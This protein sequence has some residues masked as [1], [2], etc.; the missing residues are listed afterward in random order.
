MKLSDGTVIA[1]RQVP[2]EELKN[3]LWFLGYIYKQ[4]A[5]I[6]VERYM[7]RLTSAIQPYTSTDNSNEL[8]DV[9][10]ANPKDTLRILAAV[11]GVSITEIPAWI[12]NAD[13][14]S[15]SDAA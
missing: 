3:L 4:Q 9:L 13:S 7:I 12:K 6:G 15:P 2:P 8:L 1:V 5:E 11:L 10:K 14:G